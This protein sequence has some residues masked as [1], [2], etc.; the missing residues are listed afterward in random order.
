ME[1]N[2]AGS[3]Y[4][5]SLHQDE[6]NLVLD[7]L[8]IA[9]THVSDAEYEIVVGWNKTSADVFIDNLSSQIYAINYKRVRDE[10]EAAGVIAMSVRSLG[11]TRVMSDDEVFALL[12]RE[13]DRW[14]EALEKGD[15][16]HSIIHGENSILLIRQLVS[17]KDD[18]VSWLC[19]LYKQEDVGMRLAV[20]KCL[21][22]I[23]RSKAADMLQALASDKHA[24]IAIEARFI[25]RS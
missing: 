21:L 7:S 22:G 2:W 20:A 4:I 3:K 19:S 1:L 15:R 23:E 18:P 8:H 17:R 16:Q 24:G 11:D 12:V 14:V 10:L 9:S 13:A 5:L 25:L 6:L